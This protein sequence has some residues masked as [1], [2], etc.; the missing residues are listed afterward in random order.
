MKVWTSSWE[1][2]CCGSGD[3]YMIE[4]PEL[5]KT[6]SRNDQF[7][8]KLQEEHDDFPEFVRYETDVGEVIYAFEQEGY[9]VT[10]EGY[11]YRREDYEE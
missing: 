6:F 9:T 2:D 7:G 5:G 11:N 3:H 10:V 8:D 1:C 4:I